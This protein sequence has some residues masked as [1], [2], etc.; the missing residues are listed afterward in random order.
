MLAV[1]R[2]QRP[3]ERVVL[4]LEEVN[5]L[6]DPILNH[7]WHLSLRGSG[8]Q[9]LRTSNQYLQGTALG[10][11]TQTAS[12]LLPSHPQSSAPP[13]GR[14]LASARVEQARPLYTYD[15]DPLGSRS[16]SGNNN[17]FPRGPRW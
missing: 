2:D 9:L 17:P 8:G 10:T 5:N 1:L 3:Q 6:T 13:R 4:V 12:Q 15:L 7:G 11:S 14:S 16:R